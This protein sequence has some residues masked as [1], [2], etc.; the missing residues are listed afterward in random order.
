MVTHHN[1]TAS[2]FYT[3]VDGV[4]PKRF[5]KPRT[6]HAAAVRKLEVWASRSALSLREFM[7]ERA[8]DGDQDAYAWLKNKRIKGGTP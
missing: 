1:Y 7:R 8:I 6:K 5:R 3:L 2:V 4:P